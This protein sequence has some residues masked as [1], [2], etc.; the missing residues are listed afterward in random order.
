LS[1]AERSPEEAAGSTDLITHSD[2]FVLVDRDARI[3]GYY[4]GTEP[5]LIPGLLADVERLAA[6]G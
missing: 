2:R 1:V 3:R 6:E 4:R 5:D